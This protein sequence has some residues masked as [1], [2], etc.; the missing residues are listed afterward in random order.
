MLM[1]TMTKS[2]ALKTGLSVAFFAL[3]TGMAVAQ[4]EGG[5][6]PSQEPDWAVILIAGPDIG[7]PSI[8]EG[9]VDCDP[10]VMIDDETGEEIPFDPIYLNDGEPMN[11]DG[12][13]DGEPLDP[14]VGG[15]VVIDDEMG[16]E[17]DEP[18]VTLEFQD[19]ECGGC[20][21][22]NVAGGP[23]VQRTLTSPDSGTDT[24]A[25]SVRN[26]SNIC[27]DAALYIPLLCDWQRPFVGDLMP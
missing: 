26:D 20:E 27:F 7:D 14:E 13:G 5:G 21:A 15:E 8:D 22:Q 3:M 18:V 19:S 25:A 11:I 12:I 1:K 2:P 10:C 24:M 23:E 17:I 6:D 9:T 4:D 16:E